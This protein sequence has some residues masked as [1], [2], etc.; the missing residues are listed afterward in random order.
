MKEKLEIHS[1]SGKH[2]HVYIEVHDGHRCKKDKEK[3][4]GKNIKSPR[5]KTR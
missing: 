5:K 3:E 2:A 1:K 4:N